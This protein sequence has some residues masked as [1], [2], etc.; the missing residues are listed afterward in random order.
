MD[1]F[2]Q[3]LDQ[4]AEQALRTIIGKLN[5]GFYFPEAWIRV[6]REGVDVS[7]VSI[8]TGKNTFV[9]ITC[10]WADT[11]K[12]YIDVY[13]LQISIDENPRDIT[14][15]PHEDGPSGCA[16]SHVSMIN[17]GDWTIVEKISVYETTLIGAHEKVRC[18]RAI[19]FNYGKG[20]ILVSTGGGTTFDRLEVNHKPEVIAE[21]L[22]S[23]VLRKEITDEIALQTGWAEKAELQRKEL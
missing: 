14:V 15:T 11:L 13:Y 2:S 9:V 21:I 22:A 1:E 19:L 20:E 7:S 17:T 5:V 12:D 18:D 8:P 16:F 4:N 3:R 6:H 10:E 23:F